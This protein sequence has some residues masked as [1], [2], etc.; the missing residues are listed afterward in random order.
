[1][2][3][4][5]DTLAHVLICPQCSAHLDLT[6]DSLRLDCRVCPLS[7]P[8]RDGVP[9]L[10][11]DEAHSRSVATDPEFDRL[12]DEAMAARFWGWDWSW[13]E[14][15]NGVSHSP[16]DLASVYAERAPALVAAAS[17]VLDLGT[18]GGEQLARYAPFPPLAVATESYAP[19]VAL[20]AARLGPLGVQ[21]VWSDMATHNSRGPEARNHWP[22]RRLPFAGSTFDL[23]LAR[24]S[25]FSPR[26][27][28]RI[29]KP[30]GTLLTRNAHTEWRGETLR[31]AL[32]ATPPEWT[33][34]GLGWPVGHTLFEAGFD[35][36]QW[37]EG[38]TRVTYHDIGAV[39]YTLLHV[40]WIIPHFSVDHYRAR[41]YE[42]HLRMQREG[43]FTSTSFGFVVEAHTSASATRSE[44]LQ[45]PVLN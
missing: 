8:V 2:Y 10:V 38:S 39:V 29:L 24:N 42:L 34:P 17:A 22:E 37:L 12:V 21:L 14:G 27:I 44:L 6:S 13:L 28:A 11:I 18:G 35:I 32:G 33:V 23:V 25:A 5:I 9:V 31:D 43:G 40:P 30:G 41:L 36:D 15:R 19:N 20:A 1:M 4:S 26:E 3:A 45:P 16:R 7:Y